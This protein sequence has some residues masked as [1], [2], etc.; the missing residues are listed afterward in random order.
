MKEYL[1]RSPKEV[2]DLIYLSS[3]VAAANHFRAFLVGGFVRDLILGVKNLD[4]DIVVEGN[5]IKFAEDLADFL[6]ARVVRHARFGTATITLSAAVKIDVASA[7][8]ECY[9]VPA[10]LPQV[11]NGSIKDDLKRRDFSINAM[12]ISINKKDFGRLIDFFEGI[13]DLRRSKIRVLHN[14]SFID[15]P[16]RILRAIRFEIRYDFA[17]EPKSLSLLKEACRQGML[18]QVQPQRLRDE[19]ILMLKEK[20]PLGQIKRIKELSGLNFISPDLSVTRNTYKFLVSIQKQINW[21]KENCA[22]R[23]QLE[24]WFIYFLGLTDSLDI[25]NTAT[26]CR[27][28]AFRKGDKK[29][30]LSFKKITEKFM[31][32]LDRKD[33]RPSAIFGLLENLSYEVIIAMK[34]KYSS[35]LIQRHIEDFLEI[36]NGMRLYISGDDLQRLGVAPGTCYKRIFEKV[37]T[38]KVNGTVKTKEEEL[39]LIKRLIKV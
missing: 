30:I 22:Q 38:A 20:D 31:Q 18:D 29:R 21:F 11:K 10:C 24:T 15:D 34:A 37:L 36:Y 8:V 13:N 26:I 17:I 6:K 39:L 16:T 12:A 7:R 25:R 2:Q 23:R 5:G 9:P 3:E 4:L 19:L 1:R 14:L 35:R 33:I 28:F 32:K 27:N